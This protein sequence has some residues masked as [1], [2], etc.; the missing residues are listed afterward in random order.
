[1]ALSVF[2]N[3]NKDKKMSDAPL[4]IDVDNKEYYKNP[5]F[6]AIGHFSKFVAPDSVRVVLMANKPKNDFKF[7]A[8]EAPDK[9]V[10]IVMVNDSPKPINI[11]ISDPAHGK[12]DTDIPE[13]SI[14][15]YVYWN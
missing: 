12:V 7:I 8:F 13:H 4:I 9:S 1:M 5:Q 3:P 14:Q 6:Y 2:G 11:T 15:S 10:V